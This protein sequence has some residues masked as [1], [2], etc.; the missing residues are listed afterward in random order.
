MGASAQYV[1]RRTR[2]DADKSN[3]LFL[4]NRNSH[5]SKTECVSN[6]QPGKTLAHKKHFQALR[7]NDGHPDGVFTG[8]WSENFLSAH[9]FLSPKMWSSQVIGETQQVISRHW[10]L[11]QAELLFALILQLKGQVRQL[12]YAAV[13]GRRLCPACQGQLEMLKDGLCQCL[14]CN[15]RF[16]PTVQ[17]QCCRKCGG[18]VTKKT[19]HYFCSECGQQVK[20]EFTF[21]RKVFDKAYFAEMMRESRERRRKKR[22]TLQRMLRTVRSADHFLETPVELDRIPGLT[23]ALDFFPH[24]QFPPEMVPALAERPEFDLNRYESHV[25]DSLAGDET[26]FDCIEPLLENLRLDRIFRFIAAVFLDHRPHLPLQ[27]ETRLSR[28]MGV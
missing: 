13:L 10:L 1:F 20:S 9:S 27:P 14:A 11:E 18:N 5:L 6:E 26:D 24:S 12:F 3:T 23:E 15:H 8:K 16:D 17:F 21:D 25:L 7:S 4:T 28:R 2:K 22:D 19:Y